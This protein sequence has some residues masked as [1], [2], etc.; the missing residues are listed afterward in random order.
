MSL[1]FRTCQKTVGDD[2]VGAVV[3]GVFLALPFA[4]GV[5]PPQLV[6]KELVRVER[7]HLQ[8]VVRVPDEF[9][10]RLRLCEA[11]HFLASPFVAAGS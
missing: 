2:S 10:Y 5:L 3:A 4:L 6:Q 9:H 7:G 11:K 8:F 1:S